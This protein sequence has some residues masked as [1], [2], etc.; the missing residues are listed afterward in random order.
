MREPNELSCI[1]QP[2]LKKHGFKVYGSNISDYLEIDNGGRTAVGW[3]YPTHVEI[4]TK[5]SVF[6]N[7]MTTWGGSPFVVLQPAEPSFF[8]KL[9]RALKAATNEVNNFERVKPWLNNT[10]SHI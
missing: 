3:V 1:L 7:T 4:G 6:N 10:I 5:L 2:W 8:S 9:L